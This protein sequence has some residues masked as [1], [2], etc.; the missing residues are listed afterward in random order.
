MLG[1]DVFAA[2]LQRYY[3]PYA[4]DRAVE[5]R[6][7]FAI[8]TGIF[9]DNRMKLVVLGM[10]EKLQKLSLLCGRRIWQY[11]CRNPDRRCN[12]LGFLQAV[13][14]RAVRRTVH[15]AFCTIHRIV[16]IKAAD[17]DTRRSTSR[18][19]NRMIRQMSG[20]AD[21]TDDGDSLSGAAFDS[22][23]KRIVEIA[24]FIVA[25]RRYIDHAD[26]EFFAICQNPFKTFLNILL[27]DTPGAGELYEND[28]GVLCDTAIKSI[29]K[30]S[31]SGR[32]DR[33]HHAVPAC[34][35]GLEK[36]SEFAVGLEQIAVA[37]D[38]V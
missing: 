23:R 32:D 7:E 26:P 30:R 24:L 17:R 9:A 16:V 33:C 14:R 29:G 15:S 4:V 6:V 3:L 37:D 8:D 36:R 13:T 38:A 31:V 10:I 5:R 1:Y 27:G 34:D 18:W 20:I 25:A 22:L 2:N 12:D 35:I 28:V 19:K 21:G 11:R